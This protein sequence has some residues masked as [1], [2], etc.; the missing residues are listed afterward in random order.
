MLWYQLL[1]K[2][3]C[4][5]FKKFHPTRTHPHSKNTWWAPETLVTNLALKYS[6][7][8][9]PGQCIRSPC[10]NMRWD[11]QASS[12]PRKH[13]LKISSDVTTGFYVRALVGTEDNLHNPQLAKWVICWNNCSFPM[14]FQCLAQSNHWPEMCTFVSHF[15]VLWW[16][17]PEG[18]WP[19]SCNLKWPK[20]TS[21][22]GNIK[23]TLSH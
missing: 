10:Q 19:T 4:C 15:P 13:V 9:I 1:P 12:L 2:Q 17:V 14:M 11:I 3:C 7:L 20:E 5:F 22:S 6:T 21:Q 8:W 16:I 23:V 18:D